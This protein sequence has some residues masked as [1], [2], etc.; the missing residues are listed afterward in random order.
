MTEPHA[1]NGNSI[2][3]LDGKLNK[4][5]NVVERILLDVKNQQ[6]ELEGL[7]EL[8]EKQKSDIVFLRDSKK[9]IE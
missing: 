6:I 1:V 9:D 7:K 3:S 5:V 2:A 4:Y 8:I